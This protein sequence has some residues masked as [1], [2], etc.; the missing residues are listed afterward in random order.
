MTESARPILGELDRYLLAAGTDQRAYEKLGAHPI[1]RDGVPG[2]A[3]VVW[4][5]NARRVSVVGDFN[6]WDGRPHQLQT[7][8]STGM[9]E[10]FV[11]GVVPGALY[12]FEIESMAATHV[13]LKADP[14]AAA[15]EA[16][17]GTASIVCGPSTFA[18]SDDAWLAGRAAR[19]R[20]D[21]PL[22]IYEVHLASWKRGDG[23]RYLTYRELADDLIPYAAWM[24]FT[25]I[26]LL[27]LSEFPFDGSW[28]YQPTGMF[29]PSARFGSPDD[30]RAF[31][32][33]AHAAGLGV[34]LDWV[35]GHF[36]NDPHGLARFDGT[37]LY[38]HA[39]PRQGFHPDWDTCIY[40]YGRHEVTNFLHA[41]ALAWL[42]RFHVDGLR[43]DAV[44]SMLYL[45]YSRKDGEW[46]ANRFGGRENLEAIDFLRRLNELTYGNY[47]GTITI[48]EES[49]AWPG[50]SAPTHVGGLGFGFKWNMGWMHDTLQYLGRDPVHRKYHHDQITFSLAYA[51]SENY[52]L[53]LSHDEVVHGKGSLLERMPGDRWQQFA[54]LRLLYGY[55]YAHPGKK[56]LF[57]GDELGQ[58]REWNHDRALDWD[59]LSESSHAGLQ[60]LVR[61]LNRLYAATPALHKLDCEPAGFA[62]IELHDR[63]RSVVAFTRRGGNV[64]QEVVAVC[65]FTPVPHERYRIGVAR[66]GRYLELLNTDAEIYGGSNVGNLGGVRSQPVPSHGLAHSIAI[67]V[68]PLGVVLFSSPPD[69]DGQ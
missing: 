21:A 3:F 52:T 46:I 10:G 58:T 62:W 55:M 53:P 19:Q 37:S 33:A 6:G 11:P 14:Y 5:P 49:T 63:E 9:W 12:K 24:G 4:A 26:E 15:A 27:P 16:P 41:S 34:I 69:N 48:A 25:H 32:D 56:L 50:V 2:V 45:D 59:L 67:S 18:W 47:P 31:V 29:A 42:D 30:L 44:A 7:S 22:A 64:S 23:N 66:P 8:G 38:E 57:M 28:G 40:N 68:P 20:R 54:N 43:V 61:D 1:S 36:P 35:P 65:N 51:F 60:R 13:P 17:P 39:D